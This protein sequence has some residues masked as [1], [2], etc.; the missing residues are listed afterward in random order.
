MHRSRPQKHS[1]SVGSKLPCILLLP[2]TYNLRERL[3]ELIYRAHKKTTRNK[4]SA[5]KIILSTS[6][7]R[8]SPGCAIIGAWAC[9]LHQLLD[10]DAVL[11]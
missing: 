6:M 5:L 7:K 2:E 8:L 11:I 9:T 4:K 10:T 3:R 1:K